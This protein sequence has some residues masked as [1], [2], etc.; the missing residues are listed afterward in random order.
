M[1]Q[2]GED[3]HNARVRLEVLH[4]FQRALDEARKIWIV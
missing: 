1:G 2:E 3:I 4:E